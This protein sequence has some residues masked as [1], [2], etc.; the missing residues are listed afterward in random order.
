MHLVGG[1]QSLAISA[2][3]DHSAQ[4]PK[5]YPK[6]YLLR[7]KIGVIF[8]IDMISNPWKRDDRRKGQNKKSEKKNTEI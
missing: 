5:L 2:Q 8:P 1:I 4:Y 3:A 7:R 6:M